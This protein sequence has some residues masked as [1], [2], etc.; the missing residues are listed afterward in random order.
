MK[1]FSFKFDKLLAIR[2]YKELEAKL[3]YAKELQKKI[4]LENM[5]INMQKSI[6]QSTQD[7]YSKTKDGELLNT[8][9]MILHENYINNLIKMIKTNENKKNKMNND[10]NK[11]K[12]ELTESIK[13][14][15]VITQLKNK[16]FE[17]Y[18]EEIKKEDIK[19]LDEIANQL[20]LFK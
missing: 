17:K 19:R 3:K 11:L 7:N 20:N 12:E 5:N 9:E 10:L 8:E 13:K 2:E 15:K 14:R 16:K 4:N 6:L 1:R 18:K